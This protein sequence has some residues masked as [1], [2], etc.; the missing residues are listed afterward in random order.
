MTKAIANKF[1]VKLLAIYM[2]VCILLANFPST[3]FAAGLSVNVTANGVT[4]LTLSGPTDTFTVNVSSTNATACQ[5]TSPA[6]S[7][8]ATSASMSIGPGNPF[9]PA[10]GGSS[11]FTVT[12]TDGVDN[13]TGSA[14]VFLPNPPPT[15][16]ATLSADI[17]ANGSDGP[18][19]LNTGDTYTYSWTS[20]NVTACQLTSPVASGI[21]T[22]GNSATISSGN[23]FYPSV[24]SPITI[25]LTCTDGVTNV[26]DSVVINLLATPP[27][28]PPPPPGGGG[29]CTL[30]TI[31]SSLTASGTVNTVFS[32]TTTTASTTTSFSI[33]ASV[34]PTG[35]SFNTTTGVISGTPTQS[36]TFNIAITA[37]NTC[38]VNTQTLVL[39]IAPAVVPPVVVPPA[40]GGGGGGGAAG[41][42]GGPAPINAVLPGG[43]RSGGGGIVAGASDGLECF[44]LRDY[45]RIDFQN[46]PIQ[47]MRLQAFLK[48]FEGYDYVTVN[49]VFDQATFDAVSAFQMKYKDDILTPWGHAAPTGYVYILTLKKINELYC[50]RVFPINESQ[51]REIAAFRA[52]L[53]SLRN[54]GTQV[55]FTPEGTIVIPEGTSTPAQLPIVG[56]TSPPK[57]QNLNNL[58]AA[59]FAGPP[60]LADALGCLY[61]FLILLIVLYIIADILAD[62]LYKDKQNVL[63]KFL[64]KW[65]TMCIGLIIS[66]VLAYLLG[67]WCLILPLLIAL[68]CS[69]IWIAV[70]EK[71]ES[72]KASFKSWSLVIDARVRSILKRNNLPS[73]K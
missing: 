40:G 3:V 29:S 51:A 60:T 52:L 72:I 68:I 6:A 62:V 69:I 65:T 66:I 21:S 32:Y 14:T 63:K 38:G 42:V 12:C 50:Q 18:V 19:N 46:D 28:P 24:G 2:M 35:L 30:P 5:M 1:T 55:N 16:L 10:V 49:G 34:L 22:S 44:Y 17:K 47:V 64:F 48:A 13:V 56:K 53:E 36:G 45:M 61:R 39:T 43:H 23:P 57:G 59:I 4:S 41:G 7:G 67:F 70:F 54:K 25:T 73:K 58:A 11:T 15:P 9:Y 8:I 33:G 27:P 37:T 71:H 20:T 31:N 26:S